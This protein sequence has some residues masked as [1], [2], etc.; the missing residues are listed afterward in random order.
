[1]QNGINTVTED[2]MITMMNVLQVSAKVM[3]DIIKSE[4]AIQKAQ[5]AQSFFA[6][7]TQQTKK[8]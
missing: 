1:V 3:K 7:S 8:R 2:H 4:A 6:L 5:I